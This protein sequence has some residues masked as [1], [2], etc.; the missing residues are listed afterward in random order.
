MKDKIPI[1]KGSSVDV[2][3]YSLGKIY[4]NNP[5]TKGLTKTIIREGSGDKVK[6]KIR[7]TFVDSYGKATGYVD[8]TKD[9]FIF[10]YPP[11]DEETGNILSEFTGT[12]RFVNV[13]FK[14]KLNRTFSYQR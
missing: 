6:D 10:K 12:S 11:L 9:G 2:H 4:N 7:S 14:V 1:P 13:N 8:A 3:D 5:L